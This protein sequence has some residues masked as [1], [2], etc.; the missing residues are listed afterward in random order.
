MVS[1]PCCKGQPTVQTDGISLTG[2][3]TAP[4]PINFADIEAARARGR[5][6]PSGAATVAALLNGVAE[7]SGRTVE[8]LSGGNIDLLLLDGL[9]RHGLQGRGRFASF[10]VAVTDEPGRG[11]IEGLRGFG[12][13][14]R[15]GQ[16]FVVIRDYNE[17]KT[18]GRYGPSGPM[19]FG[20]SE[21]QRNR[22]G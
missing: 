6:E 16:R 7:P 3:G 20:R 2:R 13:P 10:C 8:V 11:R 4:K 22:V 14:G 17:H 5:A 18:V 21:Y 12:H 9:V 1:V 15:S 19:T